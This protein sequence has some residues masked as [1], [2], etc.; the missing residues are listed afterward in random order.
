MSLTNTQREYIFASIKHFFEDLPIEKQELLANIDDIKKALLNQLPNTH[1]LWT[2][3]KCMHDPT[4]YLRGIEDTNPDIT[5][6]DVRMYIFI[7]TQ[8]FIKSAVHRAGL[9][10][11]DINWNFFELFKPFTNRQQRNTKFVTQPL[12]VENETENHPYFFEP[13]GQL[14]KARLIPNLHEKE[15]TFD[16]IVLVD[17]EQTKHCLLDFSAN[18]DYQQ[19]DEVMEELYF[20]A[21][22]IAEDEASKIILEKLTQQNI[23]TNEESERASDSA[24]IL[25]THEI[26][27]NLICNNKIPFSLLQDINPV[28]LQTLISP[29]IRDRIAQGEL[30]IETALELNTA[31][32]AVVTHPFYFAA[33]QSGVLSI[34]KNIKGISETAQLNLNTP[35]C[36][37]LFAMKI[38]TFEQIRDMSADA[39]RIVSDELY[40]SLLKNHS[41]DFSLIQHADKQFADD[42]LNP[43]MLKLIGTNIVDPRELTPHVARILVKNSY[44]PD[45]PPIECNHHDDYYFAERFF[46]IYQNTQNINNKFSDTVEKIENDMLIVASENSQLANLKAHVMHKLLQLIYKDIEI[47]IDMRDGSTPAVYTKIVDAIEKAAISAQTSQ[48]KQNCWV[49]TFNTVLEIAKKEKPE[50]TAGNFDQTKK[51]QRI[52]RVLFNEPLSRTSASGIRQFCMQLGKLEMTIDFAPQF[53]PMFGNRSL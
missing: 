29:N 12:L 28:Q 35:A 23:I 19:F 18:E 52:S 37:N 32:R 50:I 7:Q 15:I 2:L 42:L 6:G 24:K 53:A 16:I 33:I 47:N 17:P 21:D 1:E 5:I 49:N 43:I 8:K 39:R 40:Y 36:H 26:Y 10:W 41:I 46:N 22:Q 4:H 20:N 27:F 38:L 51:I 44:V 11:R 3:Q 31:E 48:D 34:E 9:K 30:S 45:M 14:F 25:L 13:S